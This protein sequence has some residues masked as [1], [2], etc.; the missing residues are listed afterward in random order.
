MQVLS[1]A[2]EVFPLLKTGGL[3]DVAG[4]LPGA[5]AKEGVA[6]RTLAPG[7]P[8]MLQ[9]LKK[10]VVAH[11]YASLFGGPARLLSGKVK[12]LNL[13]ILDAPHLY[14][15]PGNPYSGPDGK[16]WPDNA[17][18]FAALGRVAADLGLGLLPAYAPDVVHAHDWQA[19]LAP[20]FLHYAD[21]R[22]AASVATIH[23]IAFQGVFPASFFAEL[24]LP[25]RAF[26][27]EGVEYFGQVGFLKAALQLAGRVTT[28][29]PTYAFELR[30]EEGG[31]GFDKLLRARAATVTGILNGIDTSIWDPAKDPQIANAFSAKQLDLRPPNKRA[32]QQA[33]GLKQDP[34]ALLYAVVSRLSGQKGLDLLLEA[35][36]ALLASGAQ[37]ALVGTGD[38]VLEA[39]F[40]AAAQRHAGAVGVKLAYDEGLAHLMQAGADALLVPSRFEPCGLTQLC[41][42]RYGCV[43]VVARTGGLADTVI[44]ASEMALAA[45]VATGLQFAPVN[46]EMLESALARTAQL[47]ADKPAWRQ[48]QENAMWTDVSWARPAR[49]YAALYK[50]AAAELQG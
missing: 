9:A 14:N 17:R 18:R 47:W 41:A 2:S 23:N 48:L 19:G 16:D 39:G 34:Q 10:P 25:A 35:L 22:G 26:T 28:V 20:A 46:T 36:P 24:D 4:A 30:T 32:L 33:M 37:L 38:K 49:H 44:D 5:L 15:R 21:T 43:P 50:A 40:A 45:G 13:F 8:A 29:S 3:A 12:G 42:L 31:M 1:V 11:D 6:M 7:Y 27:F